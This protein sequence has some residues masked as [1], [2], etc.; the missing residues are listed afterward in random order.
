MALKFLSFIN[1]DIIDL[2]SSPIIVKTL[3][4]KILACNDKYL[5]IRKMS[6]NK[7]YGL[8]MFDIYPHAEASLHSLVD[9]YLVSAPQSQD[10]YQYEGFE[11]SNHNNIVL[12]T[13]RFGYEKIKVILM[14]FNFHMD[15]Y[16][17]EIKL[18]VREYAVL[19]S[20][21]Q[22]NSQK[23]IALLLCMS[24]HTVGGHLKSIY[25]KLGVHSSMQASAFAKS[26]LGMR[27]ITA[28]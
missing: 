21:I 18:T 8:T 11:G 10:Q 12:S 2:N 4:G 28:K 6:F 27:F 19:Q 5:A 16:K 26:K 9:Q 3:D 17:R 13:G 14:L 20:L 1:Q 22:G 25:L 15:N 24:R 7:L 23:Q